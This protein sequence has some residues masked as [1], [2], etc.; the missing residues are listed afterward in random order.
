MFLLTCVLC[1]LQVP[2]AGST[3]YIVCI[4]FSYIGFLYCL[5]SAAPHVA[6]IHKNL[7]TPNKMRYGCFW[8]G[9][10]PLLFFANA[11]CLDSTF[12][13]YTCKS[14]ISQRDSGS[15]SIANLRL[16]SYVNRKG[17]MNVLIYHVPRILFCNL[18]RLTRCSYRYYLFVAFFEQP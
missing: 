1:V 10:R 15:H 11:C 5:F 16:H 12:S 2:I 9:Q 13:G 18:S 4:T 17:S 7:Y 6:N 3:A 8:S 14:L